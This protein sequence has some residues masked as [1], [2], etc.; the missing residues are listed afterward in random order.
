M[1]TPRLPG[2]KILIVDDDEDILGSIELAMRAEGALTMTSKDGSDAISMCQNH[3]PQIVILDMML[4]RASGFLVLEKIKHSS[5][6]P[7]VVMI[8]A[9]QGKRHQAYAEAMGIDAYLIKPV[10]LSRLVNTVATLMDQAAEPDDE[11]QDDAEA[12]AETASVKP[13]RKP[14]AK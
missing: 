14:R 11:E 7:I 6:A 2:A 12:E 9:N 8:T 5:D 13:K 1:T 3:K 4:P 10:A